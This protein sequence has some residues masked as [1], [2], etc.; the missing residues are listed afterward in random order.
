M[1]IVFSPSKIF[2]VTQY[3]KATEHFH[4]FAKYFKEVHF[5]LIVEII[6]ILRYIILAS[7]TDK[8]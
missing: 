2:V 4:L 7:D 8:F 3:Y 6:T 5:V 1:K